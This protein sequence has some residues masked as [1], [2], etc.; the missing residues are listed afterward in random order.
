MDIKLQKLVSVVSALQHLQIDV[1]KKKN[2]KLCRLRYSKI[3]CMFLLPLILI[4]EHQE[5]S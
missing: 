2:I 5:S 1:A 3:K 4:E